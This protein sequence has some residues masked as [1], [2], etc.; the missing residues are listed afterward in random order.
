MFFFFSIF[1]SVLGNAFNYWVKKYGWKDEGET[2]LITKQDENIKTKN[3]TE[4]IAFE[5]LSTIMSK[6]L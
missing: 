4:K 1:Y 5:N 3:I 6:C 2:I